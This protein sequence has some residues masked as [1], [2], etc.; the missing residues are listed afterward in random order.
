MTEEN[1]VATELLG[2]SAFHKLTHG[3][4][5]RDRLRDVLVEQQAIERQYR[6]RDNSDEYNSRTAWAEWVL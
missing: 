6:R 2:Q 3:F 5:I 4:A 1:G